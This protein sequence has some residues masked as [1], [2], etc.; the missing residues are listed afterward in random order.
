MKKSLFLLALGAITLVRAQEAPSTAPAIPAIDAATVAPQEVVPVQNS[1]V[2]PVV[3]PDAVPTAA[4]EAGPRVAPVVAPVPVPAVAAPVPLAP[5]EPLVANGRWDGDFNAGF[6]LSAGNTDS[7]SLNL[8]LDTSYQRPDDKLSL[9]AQYLESRARSTTNG[10]VTTSITALQWRLGGRYD[11]DITPR[12]FGFVGLEFS[13]DR[14]RQLDLRSVLSS[15]LGHH[16]VKARDDQWDVYG[17]LTYRE[18]LYGGSGVLINDVLQTRMETTEVLLGQESSHQLGGTPARLRQKFV[19]YPSLF[20]DKGTRATLDAGLTLDL[21]KS[22]SL[23]MK[24]QGRYDSLAQ[25][26][27][28]KYDLLFITGLSVK[29]GS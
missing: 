12:E 2:A 3:V 17:G 8:G 10:V 5:P 27:A 26:P 7:Q 24:L 25:A 22:L 23:S 20:T 13:H 21:H 18:D 9:S 4:S 16:L 6:S 28:E 29:F 15:G 11:R 1:A 14:I 19:L